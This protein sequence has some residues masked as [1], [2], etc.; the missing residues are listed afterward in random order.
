MRQCV[1]L[2]RDGVINVK[3]APGQYIRS[4]DEFRFIPPAID[5]IRL[6][7]ALNL[8]V[9]VVTNQQGVALGIMSLA[10]VEGIHREMQAELARRGAR[11]DDVFCCVHEESACYC[12]KP[13]PGLVIEAV[14]KWDIDVA[15]SI[16][17]GDSESDRELARTCGMRFVAVD[18]GRV[19]GV[20]TWST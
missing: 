19:K 7:N 17:I 16:L 15:H 4:W 2:D 1:F 18:E 14:R 5:W 9:I 6:F 11:I 13:R 12:R 10:D 3:A 8:L 20:V